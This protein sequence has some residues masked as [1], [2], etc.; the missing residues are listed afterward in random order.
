MVDDDDDDDDDD[1][2]VAHPSPI[3]VCLATTYTETILDC[4]SGSWTNEAQAQWDHRWQKWFELRAEALSRL[5]LDAI[6]REGPESFTTPQ[7]FPDTAIN[8][9]VLTISNL[10]EK[11]SRHIMSSPAL[12]RFLETQSLSTLQLLTTSGRHNHAFTEGSILRNKYK[13]SES[14]PSS[15]LSPSISDRLRTLS[16]FA[17]DYWGWCPKMDFRA[18]SRGPNDTG[19]LPNLRTLALG[20]YVFSH[21]WQVDWIAQ[22]GSD[23]GRGGL[24]EL[25]LDDCPI[26]WRGRVHGPVDSEGF[27]QEEVMTSKVVHPNSWNTVTVDVDLRWSSVLEE[28][29]QRMQSLKVFRMG[30]GDWDGA[31]STHVAMARTASRARAVEGAYMLEKHRNGDTCHVNYDRYSMED[32]RKHG[33]EIIRD[34][35]GLNQKRQCVL[36]YVHFEI[37]LGI[38]TWVERDFKWE[39]T[40]DFEDGLQQYEAAMRQDEAALDSFTAALECHT[41]H[42]RQ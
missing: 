14:L 13:F 38:S 17:H 34:G 26:M 41:G 7:H 30:L 36:Q 11:D 20:R 29:R 33:Q 1:G 5:S 18:L 23:N 42:P 16:L 39:L 32:C 12:K 2:E 19:G 9:S 3:P 31:S 25:Y 27:P 24:Q 21:Q 10:P 22:V 15:W 37:A 8:L 4:V 40:K 35:V 28:W 6:I